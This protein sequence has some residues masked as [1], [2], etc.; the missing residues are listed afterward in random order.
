MKVFFH[1]LFYEKYARDAAA[2]NGRMESIVK[3]ITPYVEFIDCVPATEDDI[4]A[5]HDRFHFELIQEAGLYEIA[6]L[7][8]GGAIQAAVS[9]MIEPSF[10]LIRPPGHHASANSSWGFCF[11]NN[12]AISLYHLR[13]EHNIKQAYV[14]DFD[15]HEGDG[16]INILGQE[17]WVEI[18]NPESLEREAYLEEV[19]S[20]LE[21]T[22]ADIIAVSAGFDNH[23]HDWG[24]LLHIS[25]YKTMGKWVREAAN[26]NGGGCYGILEGGYNHDVLGK[27]VLAFLLGLQGREA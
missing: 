6:S 14:L 19:Y 5:A 17:S 4:L 23:E 3:E 25:D 22:Q 8:A 27:N 20:G 1:P 15:L 18:C 24:G 9:G 12:M 7:A 16:N 26:R 10:G 2:K 11:F 21:S 13:A